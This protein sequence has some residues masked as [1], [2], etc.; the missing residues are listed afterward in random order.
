MRKKLTKFGNSL[1]LIID[2]P[3]LALIGAT[4]DTEFEIR[5]DGSSLILDPVV[6]PGKVS[7]DEKFQ[8]AYEEIIKKYGS[9]LKKLADNRKQKFFE[10]FLEEYDEDLR[11]LAKN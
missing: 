5:T 11:K 9:A 3:M 4:E 8:K 6:G 1:A 7:D 2:K 10:E